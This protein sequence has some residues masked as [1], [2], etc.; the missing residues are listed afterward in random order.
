MVDFSQARVV[1]VGDLMLDR[2]YEG[3]TQRISPEAP[4]PVLS[5]DSIENR[6]GGAAN[7]AL[8]LAALG[9]QVT[10][11]GM[12]GDDQAAQELK[13]L[14]TERGVQLK[15][16]SASGL[17]TIQKI[18]FVSSHQ[19]LLRCDIENSF[20]D[21]P[22]TELHNFFTEI[23]SSQDVCIISDYAKGTVINPQFYI[24]HAKTSHV[25]VL[26][27]PKG[28]D[29]SRYSGASL[30]KPNLKEFRVAFGSGLSA[31]EVSGV[32]ENYLQHHDVG[33]LL[34]TQGAGGMTLFQQDR[35]PCLFHCEQFDIKDV[36]GAGDTVIA[37][38]ALALALGQ[39][40]EEAV[41]LA[42][43]AAGV[44]VRKAKTSSLSRWECRRLM[45]QIDRNPHHCIFS[46]AEVAGLGD[47]L[48]A[49]GKKL[50]MTNGCFD[51]L[52]PG[53]VGYLREA[54]EAGDYLL[55]AVNS[56]ESVK[57][58]KGSHRPVQPVEDRCAVLE[59]ISFVDAVVVFS[60]DTP[61][62]L[63]ELIRPRVLVKGV[64]YHDPAAVAGGSSVMSWGGE[65][66]FLGP[67]KNWSSSTLCSRAQ[68][69]AEEV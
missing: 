12:V 20:A 7:V 26:I 14:L 38:T 45:M 23:I 2:Y 62:R 9:V 52:H 34:L 41:A 27:D 3:A 19:Q 25:P 18:R 21:V 65:V 28:E 69:Q 67:D 64:D 54:R 63:V 32:A 33:A 61:R 29:F 11:I 46:E 50:V 1:V 22:H 49:Q 30:V 66:K 47:E 35:A 58:L 57:R 44:V 53:H 40:L 24:Q 36:S 13:L 60:E 10:L 31:N 17:K 39:T 55:V 8:N 59:A 6:A 5:L 15:L 51:L 68:Q 16:C 43:K 48:A 56:D 42:N 37:T 4:I